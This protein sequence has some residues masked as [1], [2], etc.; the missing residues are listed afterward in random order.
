[1]KQIR[2]NSTVLLVGTVLALIAGTFAIAGKIA[3]F[4]T[5][6]FTYCESIV[7]SIS[8]QMPPWIVYS[9]VITGVSLGLV[10]LAKIVMV[11][12]HAIKLHQ[13]KIKYHFSVEQTAALYKLG[14]KNQLIIIEDSHPVAFCFGLMHPSIYIA[15]SLL[16]ILSLKEFETILRHEKYHLEH[17]D[18]HIMLGIYVIRH[19]FPF[20]PLLT[21]LIRNYRIEREIRADEAA[22]KGT[23]ERDSLI[24]VLKKLLQYDSAIYSFAPALADE[25]TLDARIQALVNNNYHFH[26]FNPINLAISLISLGILG[27][28]FFV[29]V[30]ASETDTHKNAVMVCFYSN[31]KVEAPHLNKSVPYSPMK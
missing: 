13:K 31:E 17:K 14:L 1:M 8:W 21:D 29:P 3:P 27:G 5:H 22:M 2:N 9:L 24:S 12:I 15:D 7:K 26:S 30:L 23:G 16:T 20:F 19:F 4:L 11:A 6:T 10:T 18:T 28:I 25:E